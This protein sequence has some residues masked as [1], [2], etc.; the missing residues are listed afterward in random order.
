MGDGWKQG[1]CMRGLTFDDD[2]YQRIDMIRINDAVLIIISSN[3][4]QRLFTYAP[5]IASS[6]PFVLSG[7]SGGWG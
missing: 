3:D 5:L 4:F 2:V 1:E 7:Y 6:T